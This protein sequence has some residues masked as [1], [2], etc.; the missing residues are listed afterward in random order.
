MRSLLRV[1]AACSY[2]VESG[3]KKVRKPLSGLGF[4]SDAQL[5]GTCGNNK[6]ELAQVYKIGLSGGLATKV[7]KNENIDSAIPLGNGGMAMKW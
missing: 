7:G 5:Y 4:A 1:P 2:C 6:T 3:P